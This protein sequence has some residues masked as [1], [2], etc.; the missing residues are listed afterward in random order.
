MQ[1]WIGL[2]LSGALVLAGCASSSI[3]S[4][5][6]RIQ[7]LTEVDGLDGLIASE[8][9]RGAQAAEVQR[10]LREPL[11]ADAAVRV[12]LL[13]NRQL[14]ARLREMGVARGAYVQ[15]GLL[16]NPVVEAELLPE[17]NTQLEL[18][19][20]YDLTDAILAPLRGR[21]QSPGVD[22]ARLATAGEV[23]DLGY[24]VRSG[25][26]RLQA[27]EQSLALSQR[28]FQTFKVSR[29]AAAAMVQ[30]GGLPE[31]N[32]AQQEVATEQTRIAVAELEL[33]RIAQ[34]ER[35]HRLLGTTPEE[36][37]LRVRA[38]LPAVPEQP[39]VEGPLVKRALAASLELREIRA[40]LEQLQ[41]KAVVATTAGWLPDITV[42]VHAL[43]GQ[44]ESA[45]GSPVDDELRYGA[46]V[47][48]SVPLFDRQQGVA[49]G[50]SA[51]AAALQERYFGTV[52]ELQSTARELKQRVVSAHQ[53][54]RTYQEVI[55]PAQR[56]VVDQTLLQYNAMQVGIFELLRAH[57]ALLE[58]ELAQVGT[59]LEYWSAAA[60]LEALLKGRKVAPLV[61]LSAAVV[62]NGSA[63]S[64]AGGHGS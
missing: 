25:F 28:A 34:R 16:P 49:A 53:R 21:A 41:R 19:L 59:S 5:V 61:G 23:V 63:G 7:G 58:L 1:P 56:R 36:T 27:A 20:E 51:E 2:W 9:R 24:Q 43:H 39:G 31:L 30:S 42:D 22:A 62:N 54:A 48:M 38:P 55:V 3:R 45:E 6:V 10:L 12:A 37:E 44:P 33:E 57:R 4:D 18:R 8:P 13:N 14:R 40:R 47:S 29:D 46:G 52:V 64:E 17:R 50:L 35:V 11:D 32:F 26:Y 15:A 60:A